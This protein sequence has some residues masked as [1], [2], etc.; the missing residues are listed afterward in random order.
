MEDCDNYI[1]LE[2]SY[3]SLALNSG[4]SLVQCLRPQLPYF[5]ENNEL[6]SEIKRIICW[7]FLVKDCW[8]T[9]ILLCLC[10]IHAL[11]PLEIWFLFQIGKLQPHLCTDILSIQIS[12]LLL[13]PILNNTSFSKIAHFESY[14]FNPLCLPFASYIHVQYIPFRCHKNRNNIK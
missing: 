1:A 5:Q 3:H 6:S 13:S 10:C 14:L 4:S 9:L 7:T 2:W 8:F 12:I 11:P